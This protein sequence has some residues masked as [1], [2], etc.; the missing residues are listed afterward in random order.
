MKIFFSKPLQGLFASF[1]EL[2][3]KYKV[4][5]PVLLSLRNDSLIVSIYMLLTPLPPAPPPAP[6]PVSLTLVCPS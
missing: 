5:T 3:V 4:P 6:P 1:Q 2:S